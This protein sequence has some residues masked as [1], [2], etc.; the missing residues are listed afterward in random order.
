MTSELFH[1]EVPDSA[2]IS[3]SEK[4]T[5]LRGQLTLL[6]RCAEIGIPVSVESIVRA[7]KLARNLELLE[8][9]A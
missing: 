3:R 7:E 6:R 1:L 8:V 2:D 4:L 5:I 9:A